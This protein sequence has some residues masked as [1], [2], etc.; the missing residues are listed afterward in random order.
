[1]RRLWL[2]CLLMSLAGCSDPVQP[3]DAGPSVAPSSTSPNTGDTSTPSSEPPAYDPGAVDLELVSFVNGLEAPLLATHAGDGSDRMFVVE[4]AGRIRVV[5]DG[6][7][8]AEPFLDISDRLVSGGEQGLLGLAFHPGFERN[9]RFF[10]NYTDEAGDTVVSRFRARPGSD[11]ASDAELVLLRIDQPY[12]NHN[13]GH[14]AF[15]PDGYLYIA[16][17]DG[18]SGGDPH[19]NG[20]RLDTLLGKLLRIDVDRG[21]TYA[22]PDDNPFAEAGGEPEIWAYGLRNPW[23]FSFDSEHLWIADVGQNALEEVNR[24]RADEA[25]VN[26]GWNVMEGTDCYGSG[27]CESGG[28]VQPVAEYSHE[29]G[30]SITGG[31]VYRGEGSPDMQG[32][33]FFGD[34]CSGTIWS[35]PADVSER[36]RPIE[37]LASGRSISSFGVDEQGELY[38]VDMGAGE[39]LRV[40]DRS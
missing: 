10:V 21:D 38:M 5:R 15:G 33:Y 7:L 29:D 13:G 27:D 24:R 36:T 6:R 34:F 23:R 37:M 32:G 39:V 1:M 20:Q 17:G 30:C 9:G 19:N 4:Q 28:L 26:Y 22:I 25:G 12:A 35:I 14:L 2:A 16:T 18:G 40:T 3:P 31:Y 11:V 8:L